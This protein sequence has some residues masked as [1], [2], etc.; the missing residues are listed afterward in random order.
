MI[1]LALTLGVIWLLLLTLQLY[2]YRCAI[3]RCQEHI[4]WMLDY[5]TTPKAGDKIPSLVGR[6]KSHSTTTRGLA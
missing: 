4:A 6:A 3:I 2:R 5:L 1:E